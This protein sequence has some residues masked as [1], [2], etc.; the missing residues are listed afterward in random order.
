MELPGVVLLDRAG[1]F[2][3]AFEQLGGG[4]IGEV[5]G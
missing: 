3:E 4:L 2:V 1:E 5:R